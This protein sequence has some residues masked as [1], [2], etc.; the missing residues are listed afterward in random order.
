MRLPVWWGTAAVCSSTIP[1]NSQCCSRLPDHCWRG[2][3]SWLRH[4]EPAFSR[5]RRRP[6]DWRITRTNIRVADTHSD[7]NHRQSRVCKQ[8]LLRCWD[9]PALRLPP[10]GVPPWSHVRLHWD[11][12]RTVRRRSRCYNLYRDAPPDHWLRHLISC[13]SRT[14]VDRVVNSGTTELS[15]S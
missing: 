12:D 10:S 9:V 6:R 7:N 8:V 13:C 4:G 2:P 15:T 11:P 1:E 14:S 5:I 3:S